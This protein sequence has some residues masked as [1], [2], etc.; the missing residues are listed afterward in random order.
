MEGNNHLE[1]SGS[2][3]GGAISSSVVECRTSVSFVDEPKDDQTL[4]SPTV[5]NQ[6]IK[7]TS[8]AEIDPFPFRSKFKPSPNK[9]GP[10]VHSRANASANTNANT[11][12]T[13]S[14]GDISNAALLPSPQKRPLRS[15]KRGS[16]TAT[17][18]TGDHYE[19]RGGT[20]SSIRDYLNCAAEN[21][22]IDEQILQ[23]K[24]SNGIL[25]L[26]LL[27]TTTLITAAVLVAT[28]T[29]SFSHN[30]ELK[31]FRTQYQS[32]VVKVEEAIG[33]SIENKLNTAKTFA[34]MYT[35]RYGPDNIWPNV[36]MSDF[37][38]IAEGQLAIANGIALS[39]NPVIN[40]T[41]QREQFEAHAAE[42]AHR[43]GAKE[44]VQRSCDT[45]RIVADGIFRKTNGVITDD[46]GISPESRYPKHMVPVWQ[47]F[48]TKVNWRAVMFNLHAETNR[49]RA[50]DDMLEHQVPTI[51]ALLHLVQHDEMNPSSILFYPVF[52]RFVEVVEGEETQLEGGEKI[53]GNVASSNFFLN[54]HEQRIMGSISI[55]F[56]WEDVLRHVLPTYIEGM[57]VVLESSVSSELP[58]QLWTYEVNGEDV[59]LLG[60][61]DLH[62]PEYDNF[63][64]IVKGNVARDAEELSIV[65]YLITYKM[66]MYPSQ[67]FEYSYLSYRPLI[68]TIVVVC[69]FGLTSIIFLAYDCLI[70]KRQTAVMAFASRSGK[71]VNSLFPENVR[72]RLLDNAEHLAGN[73]SSRSSIF[74]S[75]SDIGPDILKD[76]NRVNNPNNMLV[77]KKPSMRSSLTDN[78]KSFLRNRRRSS[79][80][81]HLPVP[82][83][84]YRKSM[85]RRASM[86]YNGIKSETIVNL[87]TPPIADLF[88]ET[89]IMFADIVGF[90]EWS[91][92]HSPE[93][94][95]H[96]LETL[97]LE[98][99]RLARR[100]NVFK[101]GTIG[102]C[103]IAVT[104]I[105]DACK[106]HAEV[107][108]LFAE[109]CRIKMNK[110]VTELEGSLG[111]TTKLSMRFGIHSGEVTAGVLRGQKSRFELFGD[112]INTAS[113][114]ESN[115]VPN[116]I[117]ISQETAKFLAEAGR[118]DWLKPRDD[119]VK[120]KGKG[121]LQ[122][123]WLDLHTD[124]SFDEQNN[125]RVEEGNDKDAIPH[126][127]QQYHYRKNVDDLSIGDSS[128]SSSIFVG[129]K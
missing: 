95:F 71:I 18:S 92:N 114:M 12:V 32:S 8:L 63:E 94:V 78:M 124:T 35:S 34:A 67:R 103:Y 93:E 16:C 100:M 54:H 17:V 57:V 44:L 72:G 121:M 37:Q 115:G 65:D 1:E 24:E 48:P 99:D 6:N 96:L 27:T 33:M 106:D 30:S 11:N 73:N 116:K 51:T 81:H 97:F 5:V 104:G 20:R 120:A 62:N 22:T 60:E 101:L 9:V 79:G 108:C 7:S 43:L 36:T 126:G 4:S 66:R 111:D 74:D 125:V 2:T 82:D 112:T 107:L 70:K 10:G 86:S 90:T 15:R 122:T 58:K 88:H 75:H 50:L 109:K 39:Y 14:A 53:G 110:I 64:H 91:S 21:K 123:Y 29:Y 19:N 47:I 68:M 69:I 31:E 45:C 80:S 46:P 83:P 56:A 49:Q 105:P 113:R 61:G 52:D 127:D 26:R 118:E 40:G 129:G 38:H 76:S 23:Q 55:V 98:F 87:T 84:T 119:L 42:V 59:S 28:L 25:C 3:S 128:S 117:Q 13:C 85:M 41:A 77:A 102:D 89:S